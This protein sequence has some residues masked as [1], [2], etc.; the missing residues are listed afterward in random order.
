MVGP[1]GLEPQTS[2]VSNPKVTLAAMSMSS[3]PAS[4]HA[5]FEHFGQSLRHCCRLVH[6]P[7]RDAG[8]VT[9]HVTKTLSEAGERCEGMPPPVRLGCAVPRVLP[10]T[11][12]SLWLNGTRASPFYAYQKI[13]LGTTSSAGTIT[14]DWS[15]AGRWRAR[16]DPGFPD[17]KGIYRQVS[18]ARRGCL[19]TTPLSGSGTSQ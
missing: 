13:T 6:A 4:I 7:A 12:P 10:R 11:P 14:R 3:V 17:D 15:S 18:R 8:Y 2:T 9:N 16:F 19:P 1:W 5:G